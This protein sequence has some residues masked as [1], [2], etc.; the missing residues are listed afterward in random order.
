MLRKTALLA[1]SLAVAMLSACTAP[2]DINSAPPDLGSFALG[3][4]VV[5]APK[6][7]KGPFSREASRAD[8]IASVKPAVEARLG[9]HQGK[10]FYN[11][12]IAIEGYVLAK[13]GIP[14]VAAPKSVLILGVTVWD[15]AAQAKL[16]EAPKR[17]TVVEDFSGGTVLGSGNTQSLEAQMA[18]LSRN[19]AKVIEQWLLD[20]KRDEGWFAAPPPRTTTRQTATA[21]LTPTPITLAEPLSALKPAEQPAAI[22]RPDT[23]QITAR[24]PPQGI[25]VTPLPSASLRQP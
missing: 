3:Q 9:R 5:V 22:A 6:L 16:N 13:A 24:I 20:Q 10:S 1:T 14:V 25:A 12:G 19:A 11:L 4:T 18:N 8:W 2:G 15:D 7:T 17:F 23:T 21:S